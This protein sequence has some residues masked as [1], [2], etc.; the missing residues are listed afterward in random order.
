MATDV[1]TMEIKKE[2]RTTAGKSSGL[3]PKQTPTTATAS[4]TKTQSFN[5]LKLFEFIGDVKEEFQKISWPPSDELRLHT[6]MVV[7][8]TFICGMGIYA[9]DLCI[10]SALHTVATVFHFIFG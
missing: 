1:N 8:A 10:Q 9:I 7:G 2:A 5:G 6:K 3:N 4:N